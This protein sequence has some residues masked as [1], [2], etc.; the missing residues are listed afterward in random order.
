MEKSQYSISK[1]KEV[2][3]NLPEYLRMQAKVDEFA[4][5]LFDVIKKKFIE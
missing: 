2:Q 5:D 3:F 1:Y 4:F